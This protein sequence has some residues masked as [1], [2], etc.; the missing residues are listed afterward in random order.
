MN[1]NLKFIISEFKDEYWDN[2]K[3]KNI[4]KWACRVGKCTTMASIEAQSWY[5]YKNINFK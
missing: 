3:S 2:T 1:W 4:I 5:W